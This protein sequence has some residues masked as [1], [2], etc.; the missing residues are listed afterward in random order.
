MALALPAEVYSA[1]L[2]FARVGALA[3]LIPGVGETAVSPRIRLA[4]ALILT[5]VLF[6]LLRATMPAEPA[7]VGGLG[8]QISIEILIGLALGTLMRMFMATLAVT[9]EVVALQTT[10]AFAQTA[11]PTQ[12]QPTATVGSFLAIL[13]VTLVFATNLH[14]LFL[15]G[16]V[17]SYSLF[18]A[19]KGLPINDLTT[20]EIRTFGEMFSLGIQLA[21]P[22]IVFSL[23]FNIATGFVGRVM[24]QFQI[25][26]VATPLTVLFGL[27]IFGLSLG[28][29][30]L[31][32]IDRYRAF[33]QQF[34]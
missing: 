25:F 5:L 11:N 8:A 14:H 15:A 26:F 31:V 27:S 21:A 3:M 20:L 23:V 10:L 9:G 32:W 33:L 2:V 30:G 17:K 24:P 34:T 4:F 19:G 28:V 29:V 22:V 12:A 7:S 1:G 16:L 13:G 6:P 18:P